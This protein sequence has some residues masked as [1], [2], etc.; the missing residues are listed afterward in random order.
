V[1]RTAA[2][3]PSIDALYSQRANPTKRSADALVQHKSAELR[4][5]QEAEI[6]ATDAW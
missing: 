2:A 1:S 3:H 6:H 4:A 5:N